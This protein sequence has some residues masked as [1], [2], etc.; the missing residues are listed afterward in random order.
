MYEGECVSKKALRPNAAARVM[1][2]PR[3]T[4]D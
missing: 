4:K 2:T 1:A 3:D